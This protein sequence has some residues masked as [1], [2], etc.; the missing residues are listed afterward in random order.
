MGDSAKLLDRAIEMGE[1]ELGF[2]ASGDVDNA[3]RLAHDRGEITNRA[4]AEREGVDLD[5]L[6]DKLTQ[7]KQLQ[8]RIS[9][10]AR[11]LH[12][13]LQQDLKQARQETKRF[14]AYSGAHK[15]APLIRNRFLNKEG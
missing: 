1:R 3:E 7:L 13:S 15:P 14:S 4:V 11:R 6:L 10:E 2:L 5:V 8:G 12:A 9:S